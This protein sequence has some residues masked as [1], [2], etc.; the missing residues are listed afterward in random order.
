MLKKLQSIIG[1]LLAFVVVPTALAQAQACPSI[2]Q[3]ALEA[4]DELCAPTGRN[5]ACYGHVDLSVVPQPTA[6]DFKFET[7]GDIEDVADIQTLQLRAMDEA[8]Q[9]WGVVLMRLQANIPNTLPGQNVTLLLFGDVEI[10]N[11]VT[12][13]TEDA[14]TPMQAF[15]L[16]TGFNDSLCEEAPVSGLLVQTPEGVN[17]VSFNVNGVDVSMGSTV[18]FRAQAEGEMTVSTIEGS[19]FIETEEEVVPVLAG[20]RL[21]VPMDRFMRRIQADLNPP[22]P[23]ELRRLAGIPIRLLQRQIEIAPPLSQEQVSDLLER[24]ANGEPICGEPPYPSC[25]HVPRRALLRLLRE[26]RERLEE[27]LQCV[28]RRAADEDAVA[29]N[30]TR[31]FCDELPPELLPCVFIPAAGEPPLSPDETRPFC[32]QLP[33]GRRLRG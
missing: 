16:R 14:Y 13:E 31:P 29:A 2:V 11:A 30:E 17:E 10:T 15:V 22:E 18:L 6:T 9:A 7:A 21:R 25:D 27:R 33:E 1:L 32:P 23:Y 3:T 26:G 5:Q 19:A 8:S 12:E 4:A 28:F 20:S 24:V